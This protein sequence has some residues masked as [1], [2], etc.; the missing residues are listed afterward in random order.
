MLLRTI[1]Y[2]FYLFPGPQQ[3]SRFFGFGLP[4][5]NPNQGLQNTL[6]GAGLGGVGAIAATQCIFGRNCD[7]SFRPSLGAAI[8]ANGQFVPQLGITTQVEFSSIHIAGKIK[9]LCDDHKSFN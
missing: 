1:L 8:D 4:Q 3:D 7:L 2:F 9:E 6:A 5:T